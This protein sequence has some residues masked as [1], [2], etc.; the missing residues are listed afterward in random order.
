MATKREFEQIDAVDMLGEVIRPGDVCYAKVKSY[1]YVSV[2]KGVY[3]GMSH[4]NCARWS[5]DKDPVTGYHRRTRNI[6]PVEVYGFRPLNRGENGKIS[7]LRNGYFYAIPD[8]KTAF[9]DGFEAG[10]LSIIDNE[11]RDATRA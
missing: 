10:R 9:K 11:G 3:V 7:L 8:V 1:G 4:I 6:V 5:F 2:E